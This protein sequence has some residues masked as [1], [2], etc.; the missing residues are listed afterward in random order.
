MDVK[1]DWIVAIKKLLDQQMDFLRT[2][3]KPME[4]QNKD[5]GGANNFR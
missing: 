3:Q 2:L 5:A 1:E 4:A